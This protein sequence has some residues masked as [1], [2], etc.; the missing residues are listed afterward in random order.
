MSPCIAAQDK[1][2][3]IISLCA[4]DQCHSLTP[5]MSPCIAAQDPVHHYGQAQG[6]GYTL[7]P[8]CTDES[9]VD[10]HGDEEDVEDQ[11]LFD[12]FSCSF[13]SPHCRLSTRAGL[14]T[15]SGKDFRIPC[16]NSSSCP[17]KFRLGE[18]MLRRFLTNL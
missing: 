2:E 11:G 3:V 7:Q 9:S 1:G 16:S 12:V 13:P 15:L 17:M 4:V 5:P 14:T 18:M 6:T 8:G 10:D